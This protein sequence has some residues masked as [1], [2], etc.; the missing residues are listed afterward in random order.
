MH[1][2]LDRVGHWVTDVVVGGLARQDGVEVGA[3]EVLDHQRVDR[4][5]CLV[6]L[7]APVH[8]GVFSPPVQLRRGGA[9]R[10]VL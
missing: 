2:N 3:L 7:V 5:A 1:V 9:C 6:L 10:R 4:L 8:Q